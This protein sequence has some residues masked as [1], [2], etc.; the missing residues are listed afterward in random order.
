M[1]RA[2]IRPDAASSP[3][4]TAFL[5]DRWTRRFGSEPRERVQGVALRQLVLEP[6]DIGV[7]GRQLERA[8]RSHEADRLGG[9]SAKEAS[10]GSA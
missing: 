10:C 4:A 6:P 8:G 3:P 9:C 1:T 2:T 5:G 7:L